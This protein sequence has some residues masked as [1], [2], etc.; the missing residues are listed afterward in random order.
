[1]TIEYAVLGEP[2]RDNALS[3]RIQTGQRIVRLLFDCGENV[4]ATLPLTEIRALDAVFFSHLHMDHV[5]GFDSL[6]RAV[7]DRED[8]PNV[9]YGPPETARILHHRFQGYMWNLAAGQP[10]AWEINDVYP[11]HIESWRYT[12]DEA[13]TT[14]HPAGA[15]PFSGVLVDDPDFTV[16]AL[17]MD[18]LTPSLAYIVREK[19]RLNVT[20]EALARLGLPPGTWLQRVKTP[21]PDEAPE[22]EVDGVR[23]EL[24]A[25]RHELLAETPGDSIAYLT[26]FRMDATA[27]DRLALF[28]AGCDIAVCE[29][30]YRD[31]DAALAARHHHLTAG[32]AATMARQAGIQRLVLFHVSAR[33][34]PPDW[35]AMLAEAR[36]ILPQTDFPVHWGLA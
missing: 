12:T 2:G 29:C 25:L 15:R 8:R 17:H 20:A 34:R 22:I 21:T 26:D 27:R 16:A 1:M 4:L 10:G 19:P 33:Y 35:L 31:A 32:Q 18:H 36:A 23:Y 28:L 9:V 13:Y 6:F 5:G 11:D 7:Y 14:A 24:A 30:Q 3:V